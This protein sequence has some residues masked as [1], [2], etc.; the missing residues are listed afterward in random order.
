MCERVRERRQR[1]SQILLL[2]EKPQT[3]RDKHGFRGQRIPE[4]EERE[5]ERKERE[6][7]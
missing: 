6:A 5:R 4:R 1:P 2:A 3:Q 7:C